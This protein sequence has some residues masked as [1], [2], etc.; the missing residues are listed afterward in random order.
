MSSKIGH[1]SFGE[2]DR[3][4]SHSTNSSISS[5]YPPIVGAAENLA[6]GAQSRY[7]WTTRADLLLLVAAAS[8]I[9]FFVLAEDR[10]WDTNQGRNQLFRLA[11][12]LL[13]GGSFA[14]KILNRKRDVEGQWIQARAVAERVKSLSW[15][16]AMHV[17]PFTDGLSAT[18][19]DAAFE[20][21]VVHLAGALASSAE[22]S[23]TGPWQ[24]VRVTT[25]MR[26]LRNLETGL[27]QQIY[28]RDRLVDQVDWYTRRAIRSKRASRRWY[29]RS[30]TIKALSL[31][32]AILA[33]FWLPV[34]VFVGFGT[35]LGASALAASKLGRHEEVQRRYAQAG[36]ELTLLRA[37]IAEA[38]DNASLAAGVEAA[39]NVISREHAIWIGRL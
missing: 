16:Y 39:E 1:G 19:S 15:R 37:R 36:S 28:L 10:L 26:D 12:P 5:F 8:M 27:R 35:T 11:M 30:V 6:S 23:E 3:P 24:N 14:A 29:Q 33:V 20:E 21:Q 18:E 2:S 34:A 31:I 4:G 38:T 32:A 22:G 7:F 9:V 17:S 13:L 25:S